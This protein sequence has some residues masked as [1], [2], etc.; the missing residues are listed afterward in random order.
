MMMSTS[1][2]TMTAEELLMLPR[3]QHR[4]ELINGELKTMSPASHTHGRISA[5]ITAL[6]WQFVRANG[7]GDVYGAETGFLLTSN[8]DTVL[9]P[10]VAFVTEERAREFRHTKGY[11]PGPPD[12]A[13][14]VLSPSDR[15]PKTKKKVGQW[16]SFGAKQVWI[17][18]CKHETVTIHKS[19]TDSITFG[20]P[21][22]LVA[23][24][25]L[26][27]FSIKVADIFR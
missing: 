15:E 7:L 19:L 4:Y 11:W 14:E 17:V 12:L 6:L 3:G 23:E 21:E 27:G 25:L 18:D 8:P 16:L 2:I 10:D 9:A 22:T 13:V 5:L 1:T 26:P 20:L 24:D